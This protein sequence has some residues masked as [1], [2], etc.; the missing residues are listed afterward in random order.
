MGLFGAGKR[1]RR[2]QKAGV[3]APAQILAV[4]D[5]GVTVN[6]N[7]RVKLPMNVTPPDGGAPFQVSMK[8]LVSRVA[9]PRAGDAFMVRYDPEDHDNFAIVGAAEAPAGAG[10]PADLDAV[11]AGDIAAAASSNLGQVQRGSAAELLASGQ[12]MTAVLREFSP[13]GKT[14]GDSNPAAVDPSDPVYVFKME[15]PIA[16]GSP[17]EAVCLN[18]VPTGKVTELGL[19]QQLNV[20]VNPANPTREV[21]IDWDTSPV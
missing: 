16:G 3:D 17:L 7:P 20:A 15:L 18:R 4:Q 21:A 12:R 5:T 13:T 14:V 19:G 10:A 11:S 6:N 2:L 9:V 1:K 8:H